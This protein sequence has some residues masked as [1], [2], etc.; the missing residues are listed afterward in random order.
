MDSRTWEARKRQIQAD[1]DQVSRDKGKLENIMDNLEKTF[2]CSDLEEAKKLLATKKA[3]LVK[4]DEQIELLSE[5][6]E[7]YDWDV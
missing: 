4:T 2:S 1:K 6:L 7:A 3:K 5:E